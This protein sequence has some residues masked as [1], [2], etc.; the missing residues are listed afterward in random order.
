MVPA[1]GEPAGMALL[2]VDRCFPPTWPKTE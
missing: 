1:V 2:L